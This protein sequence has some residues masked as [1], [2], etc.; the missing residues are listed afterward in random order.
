[1]QNFNLLRKQCPVEKAHTSDPAAGATDACDKFALY[2]I[3]A[4]ALQ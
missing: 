3:V 1:M 4:E 2:R